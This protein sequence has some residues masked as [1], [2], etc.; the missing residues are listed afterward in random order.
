MFICQRTPFC[1]LLHFQ[2]MYPES[3]IKNEGIRDHQGASEGFLFVSVSRTAPPPHLQQ[4]I[5][6]LCCVIF[7]FGGIKP[8][9]GGF[10][11]PKG[12]VLTRGGWFYPQ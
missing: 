7:C 3:G 6:L 8:P 4:L 12:V 10:I 9:L 5:V 11:T 2:T 1:T